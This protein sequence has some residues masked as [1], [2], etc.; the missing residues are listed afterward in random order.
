[1]EDNERE[2]VSDI[3]GDEGGE[4]SDWEHTTVSCEVQTGFVLLIDVG[5]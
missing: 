2:F 5:H 3:S 4:M 1:V